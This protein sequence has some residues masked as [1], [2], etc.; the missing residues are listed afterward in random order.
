VIVTGASG[1]GK[2]SLLRAGLLPALARGLQL[3]GSARWPRLVIMPTKH[4]LAELATHLAVK[5]G[6]DAEVL[7]DVLARRPDKAHLAMWQAV[8][9]EA[10]RNGVPA[11]PYEADGHRLVL[12][13]DQFEQ[14]FTGDQ[15]SK[16]EAEAFITALC[17]AASNPVGPGQRPPALVVISVRGDFMD[18]CAAHPGLT[19]AL[20]NSQFVVGPMSE[21]E[22]RL[23]ITGPAEMA[24]L[25]IDPSLTDTIL[26]DLRAAGGDSEAG[27][28]PLLSQAMLLT[29]HNRE[30]TWLTS[31]AYE[32]SGGVSHAVQVSGDGVYDA[33]P[34]GQQAIAQQLLCSMTAASSD[35]RLT[36]R[37]V[38]RE[39]LYG[40]RSV[41]DHSTIDVVLDAFAAQRLIILD[42]G[43]I[44]IAH[45]ALLTAWPRLR[46]WL[47][48]DRASWVLHA[49]LAEDA[50]AWSGKGKDPSFLHR[51][52]E[53][54]AS[55][56]AAA[57]WEASPG[58]YPALTATQHAFLEAS[59]RAAARSSRQRQILVGVLVVLLIISISG[60]AVAGLA[61]RSGNQQRNLANQQRDLAVANQFAAQSEPLDASDPVTAAQLA[62]AAAHFD[63]TAQVRDSLLD[64]A[65]QPE[66]A[67]LNTVQTPNPVL[68]FSPG[69]TL[70]ATASTNGITV[71]DAATHRQI[72]QPLT[73]GSSVDALAF[74]A[75]GRLLA[76]ADSTGTARIWDV[77][78]HREIGTPLKTGTTNANALSFST[79]GP[80]VA[81][82][83]AEDTVQCWNLT[84][85]R[86][87]G[88]PVDAPADAFASLAISPD[89]TMV[90]TVSAGGAQAW[91]VATGTELGAP[92]P[93]GGLGPD[94]AAFSGN[95]KLFAAV[96]GSGAVLSNLA[97]GQLAGSA[98]PIQGGMLEVAAFSPDGSMLA[99]GGMGGFVR[100][101][102][103]SDHWQ[104]GVFQAGFSQIAAIAFSPA[105]GILALGNQA[106]QVQLWDTAT[107]RQ[108]GTPLA[109]AGLVISPNSTTAAVA[110]GNGAIWLWDIP[111][112]RRLAVLA[113]PGTVDD[114]S[115]GG[116][117]AFAP[118][119]KLLA[120]NQGDGTIRL[121]N[122]K[123]RQVTGTPFHVGTLGSG[124]GNTIAFSPDSRILAVG[125]GTSLWLFDVA[126]GRV[127]SS[128]I[129]PDTGAHG[130]IEAISFAA[131]G[132]DLVTLT[133]YM[134][135]IWDVTTQREL[136]S[137]RIAA[138]NTP[139]DQLNGPV[140][141]GADGSILAIASDRTVVLWNTITHLQI[142]A[143]LTL[144]N[145]SGDPTALAV[146]PGG[147][148]LAAA[149][150][151]AVTLWDITTRQE[152]GTPL[153]FTLAQQNSF[154]GALMFSSDGRT[155][156]GIGS[157]VWLWDVATPGN[158]VAA[159]CSIAGQPLTAR[160]W[161]IYLPSEPFRKTC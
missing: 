15:G 103:T 117:M 95:G 94:Q 33:L 144:G 97:S 56:Q 45:D 121:W 102:D 112:R 14:V 136:G 78:S 80:V 134:T 71:W 48:G 4:P 1:A 130:G 77:S 57:Q 122:P 110:T 26:G 120:V 68:V 160:E 123:T 24:G 44:Q 32:Q 148:F 47:E 101:W 104:A 90:A 16:A 62:G 138:A 76:S 43:K 92:L 69:G 39:S 89:G 63:V 147:D 23:A 153:T 52:T 67:V 108:I 61:D 28:L 143:S 88:V 58:R 20:R 25:R 91:S 36:R 12:I 140:A 156:A 135:Q 7:R 100:L 127:I 65:A 111:A 42:G 17:A 46:G 81:V 116:P 59:E 35:G 60:A 131:G 87:I 27:A 9:A 30:G 119:G 99:T 96:N 154:P 126:T 114:A 86:Q 93:D 2:S 105:G 132:A 79:R 66:R 159:A 133:D 64:V 53:L 73:A 146:S 75:N 50:S 124:L 85:L 145:L 84:T 125:V 40:S 11:E 8:L 142:G 149:V 157:E 161:K 55:R 128:N 18:R 137:F 3:A 72:G 151:N 139:S 129:A 98:L 158:L 150:G 34:A 5:C 109:D 106:G 19:S 54:A 141:F 22:L 38:T 82:L 37:Q 118:D 21:S 152:I 51:G 41:A 31:R 115:A 6:T 155:L 113:P 10:T 107:W 74:S 70:L 83:T 13:V 29:W 49:Q